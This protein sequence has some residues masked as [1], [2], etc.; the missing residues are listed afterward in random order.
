M[1]NK[2]IDRVIEAFRNYINLREE[3]VSTGSV[4]GAPGF[5]G[6][7]DPKGPSAGFDPLLGKRKKNGTVD[8]RRIP[9]SYRK[10]VRDK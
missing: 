6:A 1:E 8:F 7:A 3:G 5:S 9:P 4:A 2:K 10:W